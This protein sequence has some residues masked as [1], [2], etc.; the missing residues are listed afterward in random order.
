MNETC[1]T[2]RGQSMLM[3]QCT[4]KRKLTRRL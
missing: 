1:K 3:I 2:I 4:L